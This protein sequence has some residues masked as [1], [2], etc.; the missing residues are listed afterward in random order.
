MSDREATAQR[1]GELV[2][3]AASVGFDELPAEVLGRGCRILADD[4]C[5]IVAARGEPE[6]SALHE[7]VLTQQRPPE[8]T[9]FRG[10]RPRTDWL[11]LDEGYRKSPCHAGLYALP[12]L[13]AEAE[14]GGRS[15][16]DMLRS[17]VLSYEISTRVARTWTPANLAQHSHARYGAI[18]AA[19]A[20]GLVRGVGGTH[21]LHALTA[22]STLVNAG[23]RSHLIAGALV[24]NVWPALGAWSGMASVDWAAFGIAGS[25]YGPYDVFT[26]LL[27][28]EANPDVLTNGLGRS[29]A[30]L[31][32][33]TKV[34][35]CCQHTHAA[36]EA[37]LDLKAGLAAEASLD[38]VAEIIVETHPLAMPLA[39]RKPSTTLAGKF[40]MPH[41]VA[42]TLT[43]GEAGAEAFAANMLADPQV[44]RLRELVSLRPFRPELAPPNDRPAR[45]IATLHDG[46]SFTRE[47]LSAQGGADR[48]FPPSVLEHKIA[49]MIGPVYPRFADVYDSLVRLSPRRLGQRWD[50]IVS[51]FAS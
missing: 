38:D 28:G 22:A 2:A 3:W 10:G 33:Y 18:G 6:V 26:G 20:A 24:R 11:E 1:F 4:L 5:A 19:A 36:V 34:Y 44:A 16:A 35:A 14:S 46:R 50:E 25:P 23:P 31:D 47:C 39:N 40:S 49:A 12:A 42:V 45:V 13:L 21:L 15:F 27:G 32:G 29:W 9:V 48:P 17:L 30:V 43:T 8:A 41:V 7:H 37:A 51:E